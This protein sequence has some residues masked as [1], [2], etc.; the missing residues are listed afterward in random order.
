M[1]IESSFDSIDDLNPNLPASGDNV[2]EGDDHIR[3]IKNVLDTTFKK[4]ND[5]DPWDVNIAIDET[6][7]N[8]LFAGNKT[9]QNATPL[10]VMFPTASPDIH[11]TPGSGALYNNYWLWCDGA[12]VSR[13]TYSDLFAEI[14]VTFGAG[15]ESTTFNLPDM[16]GN[17]AFGRDGSTFTDVGDT[18]GSESHAITSSEIPAIQSHA[19]STETT[20]QSSDTTQ[21]GGAGTLASDDD[22]DHELTIPSHNHTFAAAAG[23]PLA[24]LNPYVTLHWII[25]A[26]NPA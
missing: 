11:T 21:K 15:D 4:A 10:G 3:G 17:T 2:S 19:G 8:N 13:S 22:H 12:A 1:G 14:G 7:V 23:S 6:S 25:R 24:L 9:V 5:S 16:R 20:D 26:V 18:G